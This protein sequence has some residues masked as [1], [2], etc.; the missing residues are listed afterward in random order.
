[1]SGGR[2]GECECRNDDKTSETG[3]ALG[4][5]WTAQA[6]E[7]NTWGIPSYL[8]TLLCHLLFRLMVVLIM[9]VADRHRNRP[10]RT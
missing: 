6:A 4:A 10:I 7:N 5:S 1:M 9:H 2:R 8:K 3:G